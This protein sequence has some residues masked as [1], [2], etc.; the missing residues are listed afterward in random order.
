MQ[1]EKLIERIN[2]PEEK[3]QQLAEHTNC[4]FEQ[5]N[6][7]QKEIVIYTDGSC[8]TNPGRGGWAAIFE[9]KE[10][11]GGE[12]YT[13][14]NRMELIAVIH[15]LKATKPKSKIKLFTDSQYVKNGI[16]SW[17]KN[18]KKQ[19]WKTSSKKPVLNK[20][21]WFELDELNSQRDVTFEWVKGHAGNELNERCDQLAKA[22]AMSEDQ[23]IIK[24]ARKE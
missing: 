21:L 13:T 15:A 2:I 9:D 19:G 14:N 4:N 20:D 18:W 10:I 12:E 6:F 16:T 22:R 11:S 7:E 3:V 1:L 8:L 23:S 24:V 17:I 5:K